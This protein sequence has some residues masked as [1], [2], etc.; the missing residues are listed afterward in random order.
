MPA[1]TLLALL[2]FAVVTSMTP[3]P[4]TLTMTASGVNFGFMR[5]VPHIMGVQI[6]F[7]IVLV[8]CAG[9]LGVVF[10]TYPSLQ[11]VLKVAGALYL[12]WLAWKVATSGGPGRKEA[13]KPL[14]FLQA[15]AFQWVNPKGLV[16]ALS[17]FAIYVRPDHALNDSIIVLI[18]FTVTTALSSVSW[19]GFGSAMRELLRD[20]RRARIFNIT[21][22]LLLVASIVPMVI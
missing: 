16:V 9:G 7:M 11:W 15:A 4:N 3:G 21:M 10:T 1:Q 17:T 5:T 14:T 19:T 13:A 6:G 2:T 12:C 18:I 20:P 22:A 8:A